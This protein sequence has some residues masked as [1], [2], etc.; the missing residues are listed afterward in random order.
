M[1]VLFIC[2]KGTSYASQYS[3][4][5]SG[6]FNSTRF[7]VESLNK[8]GIDSKITEVVDN[9]DID[10]EVTSF[11]P[12]IVVIEALWVVP[13]KFD[14][15][16]KLHPNVKWCVH[17]HS[18]MPFL[19]LEGIAM[20]WVAEY[21][22]RGVILIANSKESYSALRSV[23]SSSQLAYLP[24]VYINVARRAKLAEYGGS[25]HVGCFGAIRPLKNQLLQAMAAIKF[26]KEQKKH[27]YFHVNGTRVE[28][29]GN[30]VLKN[31]QTLFD[32]TPS[33]TLVVHG[34]FKPN[35]FIGFL[36]ETIDIGM[37][38]SLSETF[39]V[40][41]ADY[42]TA[43]IPIVVSKE[44]EWASWLC[45]ASDNSID[46]I[47]SVM[48]KVYQVRWLCYWNQRLLRWYS[49]RSQRDWIRFMLRLRAAGLRGQTA[50]GN[51]PPRSS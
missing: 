50:A 33:A 21:A 49:E 15:L 40:V 12:D 42:V 29:G 31:I 39:N 8:A 6:L 18:N 23:L 11:G 17:L 16:K 30:P 10:R 14:V 51:Q 27:L 7:I 25:I 9:N 2:K 22:K 24:N 5:S 38:V 35:D 26:A 32:Y 3:Y 20:Q 19:A 36:Q 43:G 46:S 48:R 4:G 13:S 28:T 37:Q 41:T 44:V 45:K 47:A 34:W 1:K